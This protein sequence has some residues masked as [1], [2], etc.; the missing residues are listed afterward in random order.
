MVISC[1][2]QAG[3]STSFS[4]LD[5]HS[6]G[7]DIMTGT[8]TWKFPTMNIM[9]SSPSIASNMLFIGGRVGLMYAFGPQEI[10]NI[11]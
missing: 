11:L 7:I 8:Q 5:S 3:W 2:L 1:S 10:D 4:D 9:D 6:Y